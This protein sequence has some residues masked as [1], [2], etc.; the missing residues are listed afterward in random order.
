MALPIPR[1]WQAD[2][3]EKF[4]EKNST[5]DWSLKLPAS[6]AMCPIWVTVAGTGCGKTHATGFLIREVLRSE[7]ECLVVVCCPLRDIKEGW[8]ETLEADDQ[9]EGFQL[10]TD[11]SITEI[12]DNTSVF[13]TSYA[14]VSSTLELQLEKQNRPLIV[15]LDE[16]HR[17]EESEDND[18]P[19]WSAAV[20]SLIDNND[21]R[22]LFCLTATPWRE[23]NGS[24]L[25]YV[26]YDKEN[27]VIADHTR[28]YAAEL[29]SEKPGVVEV[30]F[31]G[32]HAKCTRKKDGKD[33]TL[34]TRTMPEFKAGRATRH[35]GLTPFVRCRTYAEFKTKP[36]LREMLDEANAD[37]QALRH[38]HGTTKGLVICESIE[39]A[40]IVHEYL[41]RLDPTA[42]IVSSR[43]RDPI[44]KIKE[45]RRDTSAW[46]VSV[47]MISEGVNVKPI[48]VV[49]DFSNYLTL[50]D[51][52]QRWGRA[53]R[54]CAE[55]GG[56]EAKVYYINHSML[57]YVAEHIKKEMQ[58]AKKEKQDK[59]G[60]GPGEEMTPAVYSAFSGEKDGAITD[61]RNFDERVADLADW[62]LRTRYEDMERYRD[63]LRIAKLVIHGCDAGTCI[64]PAGYDGET[65]IEKP[66]VYV[67]NRKKKRDKKTVAKEG[68]GQIARWHEKYSALM[69]VMDIGEVATMV[70]RDLKTDLIR[71]GFS[72]GTPEY[73][74]ER[75]QR[76][77]DMV[78]EVEEK[79]DA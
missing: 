11:E 2:Q 36:Y 77:A 39:S 44:Q 43:D 79:R 56:I 51:I 59:D 13:V 75:Y 5:T 67:Q 32:F 28:T 72:C 24:K 25:P 1:G 52:I 70:N 61:G 68:V 20:K 42:K 6:L 16:F 4:Q 3:L 62:M 64:L 48:K 53:L 45:F 50:R 7:P 47:G 49:V 27:M 18:G 37:L 71:D 10:C 78:K 35:F 46:I 14:G 17:I 54:S 15:V 69:R 33:E 55:T 31:R 26:E 8:I 76:I 19:G 9:G 40:V 22:Q 29:A 60:D 38:T 12:D 41:Q 66:D 74:A 57:R 34:D 63:C 21:V 58:K 30:S 73:K 65:H 23:G